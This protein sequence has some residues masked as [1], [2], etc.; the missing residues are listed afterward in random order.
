M[1]KQESSI[2]IFK[3]EDGKISVNTRFDEETV[4]LT[5]QQIAELYDTA[6]TNIVEHIKHIYE[7]GE[8]VAEATCRDFR[9]VR[10]EGNRQVARTRC[11]TPRISTRRRK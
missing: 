5:Q 1:S 8:L 10:M 2:V 11:T 7:E 9:Q 4:W 3:T 6:R